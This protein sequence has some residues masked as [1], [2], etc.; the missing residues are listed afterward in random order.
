MK[1]A[2]KMGSGAM[3]CIPNFIKIGSGIEKLMGG[4]MYRHTDRKEITKYAKKR[5]KRRRGRR[6]QKRGR[7]EK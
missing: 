4:G 5:K 1:Y 7:K 6:G 2:F 3:I